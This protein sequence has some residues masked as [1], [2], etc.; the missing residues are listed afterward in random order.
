MVAFGSSCTRRTVLILPTVGQGLI[1]TENLI[2]SGMI[3]AALE[4]RR[5]TLAHVHEQKQEQKQKQKK[6]A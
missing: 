4:Q 1:D 2:Q 3:G 6:G 5:G